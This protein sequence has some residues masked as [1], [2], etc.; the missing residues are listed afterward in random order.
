MDDTKSFQLM[1]VDQGE[2]ERDQNNNL[3]FTQTFSLPKTYFELNFPRSIVRGDPF[4]LEIPIHN[5]VAHGRYSVA[6]KV[7]DVNGKPVDRLGQTLLGKDSEI[8]LL[9][10][11]KEAGWY[12]IDIFVFETNSMCFLVSISC[13]FRVDYSTTELFNRYV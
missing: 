10:Q 12:K 13:M 2:P 1:S 7:L 4:D 3:P 9:L 11:Y 8:H 5:R 6:G